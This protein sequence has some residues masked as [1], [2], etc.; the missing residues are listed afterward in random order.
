MDVKAIQPW[1]AAIIMVKTRRPRDARQKPRRLRK[2]EAVLD[3]G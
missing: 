1:A 2:I 3:N